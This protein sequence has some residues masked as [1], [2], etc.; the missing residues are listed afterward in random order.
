MEEIWKD[1][2]NYEGLYQVSNLGNIKNI[3]TKQI[4]GK[5]GKRYYETYLYKNGKRKCFKIHRLVAQAFIPNLNNKSE[6]NHIDGNRYNN[7]VSNLEWVTRQENMNHASQHKLLSCK[8]SIEKTRK[9]IEAINIISGEIIQFKS[10]SEAGRVLGI[11]VSNICACCK[12]RV[13]SLKSYRFRYK[14]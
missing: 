14:K 4:L 10:L 3:L 12:G 2:K 11:N 8:E 9:D 7:T 6:V 5:F 1:I 13:K